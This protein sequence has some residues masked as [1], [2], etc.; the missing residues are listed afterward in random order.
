MYWQ[1]TVPHSECTFLK[2]GLGEQKIQG[3][4]LSAFNLGFKLFEPKSLQFAS[5]NIQ[6]YYIIIKRILLDSA[7][8]DAHQNAAEI[9]NGS[10]KASCN[11]AEIGDADLLQ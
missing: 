1:N 9:Q 2:A 7:V 4:H 5:G 8:G 3:L 10:L 11:R 6:W